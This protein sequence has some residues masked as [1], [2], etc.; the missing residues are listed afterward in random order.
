MSK[1]EALKNKL[2]DEYEMPRKKAID[3]HKRLVEVLKSKKGIKKELK[4]Q[5]RELSEIKKNATHKKGKED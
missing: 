2:E 3:E 4:I 5:G 1:H